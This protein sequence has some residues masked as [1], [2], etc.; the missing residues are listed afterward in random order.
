MS[1]SSTPMGASTPETV[2]DFWALPILESWFPLL[3]ENGDRCTE[4]TGR[5]AKCN[6]AV[7]G[8]SIRGHITRPFKPA[9]ML[10]AWGLCPTCMTLTHFEYRVQPDLSLVGRSPKDGTWC[11]WPAREKTPWWRRLFGL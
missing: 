1:P 11:V 4:F 7:R 9:Y 10:D 2:A 6:T 5:C 8:E 3:F